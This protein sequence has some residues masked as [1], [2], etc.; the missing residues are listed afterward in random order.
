MLYATAQLFLPSGLLLRQQVVETYD[1]IVLSFSP[2]TCENHAMKF[3]DAIHL[4]DTL[5]HERCSGNSLNGTV[6]Y[7]CVR[8]TDGSWIVLE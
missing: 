7:A 3:V 8:D 6:L 1:G 5:P 4:F 2:F